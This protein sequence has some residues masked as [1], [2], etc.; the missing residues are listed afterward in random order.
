MTPDQQRPEGFVGQRLA[1]YFWTTPTYGI[2][3]TWIE[4]GDTALVMANG[5]RRFLS[6]TL[7]ELHGVEEQQEEAGRARQCTGEGGPSP[8]GRAPDR[9][10]PPEGRRE[11]SQAL[12]QG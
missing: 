2:L 12:L 8:G 4:P 10:G 3:A 6:L 1:S 5:P 9:Q 7:G 11:A